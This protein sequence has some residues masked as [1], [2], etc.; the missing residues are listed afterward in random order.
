MVQAGRQ[1]KLLTFLWLLL[2]LPPCL[3]AAPDSGV[4]RVLV[5][6]SFHKG[7]KWNDDLSRGISDVLDRKGIELHF[8]YMDARRFADER[9][10]SSLYRLYRDKYLWQPVDVIISTDE[11]ALDFLLLFHEDLFPDVPVVFCGV[12]FLDENRLYGE[13]GITGLIEL[14]DIEGS[15]QLILELTPKI[16][17]VL[18][19]TDNSPTSISTIKAF[20]PVLRRYQDRFAFHFTELMSLET[21]RRKLASLPRSS[22]VLLVNYT[23]DITGRILSMEESARTIADSS[24]VPVYALWDSYLGNGILGGL[25]I[26]GYKQGKIAAN[27]AMALLQGRRVEHMPVMKSVAG[28]TMFDYRQ[29]KRFHI[30]ERR[31]PKD[32][33]VTHRPVSFFY[34]YRM[35]IIGVTAGILFLTLII[36][37]LSINIIKRRRVE[38]TLKQHEEELL[39]MSANI[40]EAQERERK[41]FSVDL[42]DEFGQTL[43][44][45][46]LNLSLIKTK[47]GD[48]CSRSV[49]DRLTETENSIEH[50][51]DQIH[52]LSRDLR[53]TILDDLG[54]A[55]TLRWYMNQYQERTGTEVSFTVEE[56]PGAV[57]PD[58]VA[59]A[60]YRVLQEAM[61]NVT[62]YARA[63]SV[64]AH[65]KITGREVE[66]SVSDNGAGFDLETI[67]SRRIQDRGLG[68]VGMRERLELLKGSLTIDT[69]PGTGTT[70]TAKIRLD[71]EKR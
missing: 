39:S 43:T 45:V 15:I 30:P 1:A 40:I 14:V 2:L 44:A 66:L 63:K 54:L 26:S 7:Q 22:A 12:K 10:F 31:L 33:I 65:L 38:Q 5:L 9:H 13:E 70:L 25:L 55:P 51:Y 28:Q 57:I 21:L 53:P 4:Q 41:R 36:L 42:H 29:L 37:V 32:A 62:K 64:D 50:L 60:L 47:L 17:Q 34:Q 16:E 6:H 35:L 3:T 59:V 24:P 20:V 27:M 23:R 68:L 48:D 71:G 67:M 11:S 49:A 56:T 46:G 69:A 18:V 8:E 19:V 61:T 52:D 58:A